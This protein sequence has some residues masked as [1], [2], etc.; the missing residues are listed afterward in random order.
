MSNELDEFFDLAGNENNV[1]VTY[2]AVPPPVPLS[3]LPS[4]VPGSSGGGND[5]VF[6][7]IQGGSQN[8]MWLPSRRQRVRL[9]LISM[10][11][12]RQQQKIKLVTIKEQNL[13]NMQKAT[14]FTLLEQRAAFPL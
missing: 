6:E 11:I 7:S 4:A 1:A 12:W 3:E 2:S 5:F 8:R 10:Q 13:A 14:I 9:Q